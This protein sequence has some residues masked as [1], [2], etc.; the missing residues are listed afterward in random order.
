MFFQYNKSGSNP[1]YDMCFFREIE[2]YVWYNKSQLFSLV[3]MAKVT[4]IFV[5]ENDIAV[6]YKNLTLVNQVEISTWFS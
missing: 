2:G 5:H 1:I 6:T 4:F 3:F